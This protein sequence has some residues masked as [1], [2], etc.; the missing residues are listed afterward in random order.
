MASIKKNM[1]FQV[2]GYWTGSAYCRLKIDGDYNNGAVDLYMPGY[3]KSALHKYQHPTTARVEH[4]QHTY[5]PPV[6][7]T[8]TQY[9]EEG[10]DSP[11]LSPKD[12][13]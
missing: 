11:F 1:R 13:N 10:E 3:I 7:R 9:S 5:N 12:V 4:V 2:T 6:Y 8:K